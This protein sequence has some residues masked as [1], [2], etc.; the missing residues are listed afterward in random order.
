V[1]CAGEDKVAVEVGSMGEH[2]NL[3]QDVARVV[4]GELQSRAP[5]QRQRRKRKGI[6]PGTCL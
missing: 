3:Q 6:F 1:S 5:V 2:G 4:S